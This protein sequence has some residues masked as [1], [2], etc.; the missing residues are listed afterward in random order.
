[1]RSGL[2]TWQVIPNKKSVGVPR[3][4]APYL[5]ISDTEN[6]LADQMTLVPLNKLLIEQARGEP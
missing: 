3:Q 1:M 6:I 2:S 5:Q 4:S